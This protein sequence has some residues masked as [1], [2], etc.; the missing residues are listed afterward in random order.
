M[1]RRAMKI[2]KPEFNKIPSTTYSRQY[3]EQSFKNCRKPE[4]FLIALRKIAMDRG[5]TRF[6]RDT[7]V[8]RAHLYLTLTQS[9]NPRLSTFYRIINALGFTLLA[10]PKKAKRKHIVKPNR[11][12]PRKLH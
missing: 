5:F 4:D 3:L 8:D 7:N 12:Q 1:V 2:S 11:K 10:K 9:G 6:S